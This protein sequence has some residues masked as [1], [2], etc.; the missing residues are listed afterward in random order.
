VRPVAAALFRHGIISVALILFR[1][2]RLQFALCQYSED[3][4]QAAW[5]KV[6]LTLGAAGADPFGRTGATAARALAR[7]GT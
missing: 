4:S 7:T 2:G 1:Y 5:V 3:F 6:T